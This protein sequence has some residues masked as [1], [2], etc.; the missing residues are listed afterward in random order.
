M[1]HYTIARVSDPVEWAEIA[2]LDVN[3][4]QWLPRTDIRMKAQICYSCDGLYVH[5][6][7]WETQIRA[8]HREPLSM[9][10]EDSCMEFFFRPQEGDLRY[11]NV[12]IN[13]NGQ[14]YIGFG[15]NVEELVRLVLPNEDVLL[16]K[17]VVLLPDG[18][19]CFY[20][21]PISVLRIFFPD[22][23]LTSGKKIYANC[24]K[25]GDKTEQPH[26]ISWN[27]IQSQ[28]PCF[29]RPMDFGEM[30]LG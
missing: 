28:T 13:P 1:K 27:P 8:V 23:Q 20:C 16:Q 30:L 5:M 3:N 11:F 24:Y 15:Y 7:A 14:T 21:I 10:C 9:V 18:W 12:E 25:C 4:H 19:E 26:Y 6:R 29:H 22:Y 17:R 2:C